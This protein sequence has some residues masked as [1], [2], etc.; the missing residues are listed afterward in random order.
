VLVMDNARIHK[1]PGIREMVEERGM[2]LLFLPAYSPDLNSIEEAF[3]CEFLDIVILAASRKH[4]HYLSVYSLLRFANFC[5][6]REIFKNG[7]VTCAWA[8]Q[9]IDGWSSAAVGYRPVQIFVEL[10]CHTFA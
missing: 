1:V 4:Q 10:G 5:E 3:S 2:R 9:Q 6:N 8:K 7:H